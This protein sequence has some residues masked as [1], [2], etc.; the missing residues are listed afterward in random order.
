MT[1]RGVLLVF[2]SN[3]SR[4]RTFISTAKFDGPSGFEGPCELIV[5]VGVS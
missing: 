2:F 4:I 5:A 3:T 1:A